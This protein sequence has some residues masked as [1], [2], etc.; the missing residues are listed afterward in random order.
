MV[1]ARPLGGLELVA[2]EAVDLA[3]ETR[4]V[5]LGL[6]VQPVLGLAVMCGLRACSGSS[7]SAARMMCFGSTR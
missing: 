2:G 5:G 6:A 1:R 4:K 3:V 7:N